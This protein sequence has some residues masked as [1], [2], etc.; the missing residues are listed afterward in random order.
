MIALCVDD[1][2]ILLDALLRAVRNS[3][4]ITEAEGFTDELAALAWAAEKKP[5]MAFL[6]IRLRS[7][8]GLE[9]ASRLKQSVPGV[10]IVFCT[11]H[12]QYA[13]DA[14]KMH[15]VTGYLLKPIKA[16]EVQREIDHVKGVSGERRAPLLKVWCR[17][18]FEAAGASG[19]RLSFKRRRAKELLAVLVDRRGFGM[20]S[21]EICAV[22]FDDDGELDK[23]NMDHLRKLFE[24]L[25]SALKDAGAEEVLCR[26]DGTSYVNAELISFEDEGDGYGDDYMNCYLWAEKY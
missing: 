9:L 12:A 26:S 13:L 24:D 20:T 7:M 5:D 22:M 25:K 16:S 4:D 19:E 15:V 17:G 21:K 1:E 10:R 18:G 6:D 2:K 11:G 3:P 23:R 14:I 8:D